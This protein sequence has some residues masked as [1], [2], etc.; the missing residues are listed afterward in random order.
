M[1][2]RLFPDIFKTR[3]IFNSQAEEIF[4]EKCRNLGPDWDVYFSCV[5]SSLEDHKGLIENEIDFI[6]YHPSY[7]IF[8]IEVK[9]GRIRHDSTTGKYYSVNRHDQSFEIKNP[10]Q[11]ALIFKGR[12]L[13]FLKRRRIKAPVSHAVCMPSINEDELPKVAEFDDFLVIGRN[14]LNNIEPNLIEIAKKA[15]P[16]QFLSF[17]N[18]K[19]SLQEILA[20]KNFTTKMHLREYIDSNELRVD[21][22]ASIQES[23]LTPITAAAKMG[24]E[25]E[26]GTGKTMIAIMLAKHFRNLG[27][28]VLLLSSNRL[29]NNYLK[30]QTGSDI[31]VATYHE[32]SS[33][34][35]AD[36]LSPPSDF[37]GKREDWV[38]YEA[39]D[40]FEQ[41]VANSSMRYDVILCDEAQDVQPF[42][43]A[44]LE[45][46]LTESEESKFYIF[47]D[48]S[49]GIFGSGG[50]GK[51]FEPESVL[52]VEP[53]YFPLIHNYRT[54]REIASIS[55][56]FRTGKSI[57]QAHC[58]RLGHVPKLLCYEDAQDAKRLLGR[59][60]RELLKEEGLH[61]DE[62]TL[63]S[64]RNPNSKESILHETPVLARYPINY[65]YGNS[66]DKSKGIT[67]PG[68][69]TA[70]TI[71]AFKGLETPVAIL[72]NVSEYNLPLD[73]PI[74]SSLIYV[75]CSRAKHMLYI[76]VKNND[77]KKT[78]FEKA[79][80][81]IQ[82]EGSVVLGGSPSDFEFS[83]T[84][85]HYNPDRVGILK[86][87]DPAFQKSSILFF[88]HDVKKASINELK[89]GVKLKFRPKI[90]GRMTVAA[91]LK[92]I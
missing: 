26:A 4:Y 49:Q 9:G 11:Q 28:S 25:G 89:V 85:T 62:I 68:T 35:Y 20:G 67:K 37:E 19:D 7:G 92:E 55:R 65:V 91:D 39:P 33:W 31:E 8:I 81:S 10:F 70:S 58:G 79:I 43:W 84:V 24:I 72:L 54:T 59:L 41:A 38:Q 30:E 15:H 48:R 66:G 2:P 88:P 21:D 71:P 57:L 64:A 60:I 27:K 29:L 45:K 44:A 47:F 90:E 75:A 13:R 12:F 50:R 56:H 36:L 74:M 63:L 23:F 42:W 53:P 16:P 80:A 22:V 82:T 86:V 78:F 6:L 73:N 5:L 87:K 52:P 1:M 40:R 83:G 32:V 51:T 14:R 61:P 18:I 76:L 77:P 46:L 69:I 34:F 17:D 3:I